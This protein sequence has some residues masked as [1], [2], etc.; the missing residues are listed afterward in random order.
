VARFSEHSNELFLSDNFNSE[1][2][3]LTVT[4]YV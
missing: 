3:Q 1:K 2:K 4:I